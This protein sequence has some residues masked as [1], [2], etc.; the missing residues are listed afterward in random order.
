MT[1]L[2]SRL[3]ELDAL[4]PPDLWSEV[5]RRASSSPTSAVAGHTRWAMAAPT[6]ARRSTLMFA[7]SFVATVAV[8]GVSAAL[9][10][11]ALPGFDRRT[12]V[13]A[14]DPSS[15]ASPATEPAIIWDTGSV[16]LEADAL[17]IRAG[18]TVF[19]GQA[20][21]DVRSD[22]GGPTYRTLEVEW[23]EDGAEQRLYLYFA[24]DERD[25]WV[26]EVR[27]RDGFEDP[28]WI[29]YAE[30][31]LLATPRGETWEGDLH[32]ERG[33]GRVPGT[34]V[35]EGLRLTA[36]APASG[37]GALT[38]CERV[39]VSVRGSAEPLDSGQPLAGT[40]IEEMTP[41]AA[42][43]LLREMG[44]CFTFRYMYPTGDED[45]GYSERWCTAPPAGEVVAVAYADGEVVVVVS[46]DRIQE[47]REQPLAGWGCPEG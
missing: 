9:L 41:E 3:R 7:T 29:T 27:T 33:Q 15:S 10:L 8:L 12:D 35:I 13:G 34:L 19:R 45:T 1:D 6:P 46:D 21:Y 42:E 17:E 14:L 23:Q 18:D 37:P 30:D 16:R 39:R 44:L 28:D 36:F 22:P 31:F 20:P 2:R 4:T 38:D 24:A 43:A 40:G 5:E 11:S 26:S 47:P 32:L 25:W